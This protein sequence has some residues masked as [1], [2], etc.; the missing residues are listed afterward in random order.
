MAKFIIQPV[1]FFLL[2]MTRFGYLA[3]IRWTVCIWT[4]QKSLCV[5]FSRMDSGLCIY[6]VV[7][8]VIIIII[9]IIIPWG[10]F[11]SALADGLSLEF[12]WQQVSLSL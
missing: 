9:I 4:Y 7:A 8:V 11:T 3:E 2:T 1:L 12:E 5:S 10:F 6:R